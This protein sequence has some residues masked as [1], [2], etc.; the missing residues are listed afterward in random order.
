MKQKKTMS[1]K[2]PKK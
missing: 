1:I 2:N